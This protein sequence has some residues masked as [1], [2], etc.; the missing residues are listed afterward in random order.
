MATL[1]MVII[2][3]IDRLGRPVKQGRLMA[4]LLSTPIRN[5]NFAVGR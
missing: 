1:T 4:P 3:T 2:T 5:S